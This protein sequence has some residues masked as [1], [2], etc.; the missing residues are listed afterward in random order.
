MSRISRF[1][2]LDQGSV[3][4][5]HAHVLSKIKAG[6]SVI[7]ALTS[8]LL[9]RS[10]IPLIPGESINLNLTNYYIGSLLATDG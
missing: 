8:Y 7:V 10:Q 4:Y 1:H 9:I 3:F 2:V 5:L 6:L